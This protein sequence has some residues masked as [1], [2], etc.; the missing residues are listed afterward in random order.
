MNFIVNART[1]TLTVFLFFTLAGIAQ[2]DYKMG[3]IFG[4]NYS[5]LRS[6]LFTM[7]S[8]RLSPTAGFSVTLGF[9]DKFELNTEIALAQNGAIVKAVTFNPENEPSIRTYNFFYNTFETGF[10]TGYQPFESIPVRLQ[11]GGFFGAHF[12]KL[13]RTRKDLFVGDYENIVNAT[14]VTLLN[15]SMAGIDFGPVLGLS[16]GS[17]RFRLNARYYYGTRNLYKNIAFA[18]EGPHIRTSSLR[19]ALVYFFKDRSTWD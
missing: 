16:A 6:D 5:G 4:S 3:V 7:S 2:T 14:Q 15:E 1:A 17:G 13:D 18:Q 11:A 19:L 8:G 10:Y 12:H 9:G